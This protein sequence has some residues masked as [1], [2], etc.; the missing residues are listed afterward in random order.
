MVMENINGIFK[1]SKQD[2]CDKRMV[3]SS[4]VNRRMVNIIIGDKCD[5]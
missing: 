1:N 4:Q 2:R 3:F 5:I